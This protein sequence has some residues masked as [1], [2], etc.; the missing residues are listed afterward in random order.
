MFKLS[1]WQKEMLQLLQEH[2]EKQEK[3]LILASIDRGSQDKLVY[4]AYGKRNGNIIILDMHEVVPKKPL[5][6]IVDELASTEPKKQ[7][8][9]QL[10]RMEQSRKAKQEMLERAK[11]KKH[12]HD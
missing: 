2:W 3:N 4:T 11:R 7:R 1:R 8:E 5:Y 6:V 10:T 9:N 12:E